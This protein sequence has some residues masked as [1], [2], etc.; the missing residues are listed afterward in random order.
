MR[1]LI[2]D[3]DRRDGED[4]VSTGIYVRAKSPEGRWGTFDIVQLDAPSLLAWLRSRGGDNPWAEDVVGLLLGHEHLHP[5]TDV[6]KLA[7]VG[8]RLPGEKMSCPC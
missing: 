8:E 5:M 7:E 4:F 2:V 1:E 3:V 6:E